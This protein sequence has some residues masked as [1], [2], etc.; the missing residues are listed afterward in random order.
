[1]SNLS[2]TW[3]YIVQ[4]HSMVSHNLTR[5]YH[6]GI[7]RLVSTYS[8]CNPVLG[9][10]NW[11][12]Q[13]LPKFQ[14]SRVFLD[15]SRTPLVRNSKCQDLA[16]FLFPGGGGVILDQ[17]RI[18]YSCQNEQKFAMPATFSKALHCRQSLTYYVCGDQLEGPKSEI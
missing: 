6:W 10:Q 12:C 8:N 7:Q 17:A 3:T 14:F 13:D 5:R 9:S 2:A 18:G 16:N 1:M 15:K 4:F 11:K